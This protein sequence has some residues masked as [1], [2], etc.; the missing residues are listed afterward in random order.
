MILEIHTTPIHVKQDRHCIR[1]LKYKIV[2]LLQLLKNFKAF[3]SRLVQCD[4]KATRLLSI[5]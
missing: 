3:I 4:I 5:P 2:K 1:S